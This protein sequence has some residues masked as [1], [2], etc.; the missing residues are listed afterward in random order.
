MLGLARGN[1]ASLY[2]LY[3]LSAPL[4][5]RFSMYQGNIVGRE[6]NYYNPGNATINAYIQW[7]YVVENLEYPGLS[8]E[9]ATIIVTDVTN[10]SF[11]QGTP[12][13]ALFFSSDGEKWYQYYHPDSNSEPYLT[14]FTSTTKYFVNNSGTF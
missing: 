3:L 4:V 13:L 9:N 2:I 5:F 12:S 10:P 6:T 14:N 11:D 7:Q 8:L 1:A